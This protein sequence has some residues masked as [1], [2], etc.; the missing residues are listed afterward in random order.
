MIQKDILRRLLAGFYVLQF[1]TFLLCLT[2][3]SYRIKE[4]L[5]CWLFFCCFFAV[6]AFVLLGALLAGY[7]GQY[8]L[9]LVGAANTV[10]PELVVSL[11]QIP[12]EVSAAPRIL[13]AGA[14]DPAVSTYAALPALDAHSSL[15]AAVPQ[16][17]NDDVLK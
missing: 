17:T 2:C 6:L 14:L 11:A 9:N 15:L 12:Q 5:V 1:C 16:L 3:Y 13:V 10:I 8:L 4:L 7:A